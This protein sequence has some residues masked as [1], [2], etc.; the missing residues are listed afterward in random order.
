MPA[1]LHPLRIFRATTSSPL[2]NS[3]ARPCSA[4]DP[5]GREGRWGHASA[6]P[7]DT[8]VSPSPYHCFPFRR[9]VCDTAE[10]MK[11][12]VVEKSGCD[13]LKRKVRDSRGMGWAGTRTRGR[14]TPCLRGSKTSGASVRGFLVLTLSLPTTSADPGQRLLRAF[15]AHELVLRRGHAA[16]RGHCLAD[17]REHVQRGKGR[18]AL[19]QH[20]G[21]PVLRGRDRAPT[22]SAGQRGGGLRCRRLPR[23]Q[24]RGR[25]RGAPDPGPSGPL[26]HPRRGRGQGGRTQHHHDRGSQA[27]AHRPL[28]GEASLALQR[29]HSLRCSW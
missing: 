6:Q 17:Q 28:P 2:G 22:P 3:I 18:D 25:C 8:P 27:W 12:I 11:R 19:R 29:Q 9:H 23:A 13:L 15:D 10:Q 1:P 20:Q 14:C 7:S 16:S 26:H 5:V 24:R 4:S 21:T